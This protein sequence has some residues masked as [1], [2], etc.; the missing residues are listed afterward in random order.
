M[1][2]VIPQIAWHARDPVLTLD[3]DPKGKSE[4]GY[5]RLATGGADRLLLVSLRN[6]CNSG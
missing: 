3:F 4:Q 6:F 5:Y 1:R 2:V